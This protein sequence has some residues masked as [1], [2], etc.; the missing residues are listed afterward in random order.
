LLSVI[1]DILDISKIEAGKMTVERIRCA[2]AELVGEVA[3]LMRVRSLEKGLLFE[4][5]YETPV[6]REIESDPTRLRQILI[7][8]I[9]NAIKFTHSGFVRLLVR[10]AQVSDRTRLWFEVADSGIGLS[11]GQI[12]RLFQ[13]F[14]Q[15]DPSTTRRFGG[16][17]LGLIICQRLAGLLGGCIEVESAPGRGSSFTFT[18]DVSCPAGTAMVA[19]MQEGGIRAP[20]SGQPAEP[21]LADVSVLLAEDGPDNQALISAHLRRAGARVTLADNGRIAVAKALAEAASGTPFDVILMDMQM[22]ELDGYGATSAL[23]S[24]GYQGAIIALTA[25]AM[26]SD[27]DKCI[28]AGCTDYMTK[29]IQRGPL[30]RIVHRHVTRGQAA[31]APPAAAATESCA[32]LRSEYADDPEWTDLLVSFGGSLRDVS[33][34]LAI[35]LSQG[36]T[37]ALRILSHH[38][39][40]TGGGYGFPAISEAAAQLE[41]MV[42]KGAETADVARLTAKLRSLCEGAA[43]SLPA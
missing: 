42:T 35:A 34:D 21:G 18:L 9:G 17:G 33:M 5:R 40:D 12:E 16:T 37:V 13:P 3:S 41:S 30:L 8:L 14:S 19:S 31:P 29:P 4:V 43:A 11:Q 1:N 10:S 22:P 27:R 38:L 20:D 25:H 6:P 32:A 26:A 2:P 7:N 36:N 24:E 39:Q 23:R 15:A 28:R